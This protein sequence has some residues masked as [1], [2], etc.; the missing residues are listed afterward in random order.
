MDKTQAAIDL[1]SKFA[2]QYQDKFMDVG[3]YAGQLDVVCREITTTHA[4]IL[5]VAC[6][7]GNITRY[8]LDKKPDFRILGTD[9][10]EDMLELARV[11]NPEAVFQALDARAISGLNKLF[12]GVIC[13]FGLPYL[14]KE[15][16]IAFIKDA[17]MILR[18]GGIIY[19]STME[20]VYSKSGLE[21]SSSGA[22]LFIHYHEQGYLVKTLEDSGF[23][24]IEVG[25][26]QYEHNGKMVNDLVLVARKKQVA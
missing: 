14:N 6:G 11:N 9:L 10:S 22:Q 13:G 15:E 19:L 2:K 18:A 8:L 4:E 7:P 25:H 1:F 3:M 20:D 5:D 12:D 16:A 21:A 24:V 17:A 23:E 26:K